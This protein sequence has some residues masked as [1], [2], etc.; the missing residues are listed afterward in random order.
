MSILKNNILSTPSITFSEALLKV[1][2]DNTL[3]GDGTRSN[4]LKVIGGGGGGGSVTSI[5]GSSVD[6]TNPTTPIINAIPMN[7]VGLGLTAIAGDFK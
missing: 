7:A 2:H 3:F 6:N 1:Y 5:T 4:P